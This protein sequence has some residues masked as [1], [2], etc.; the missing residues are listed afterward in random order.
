MA[1]RKAFW[2]WEWVMASNIYTERE[3]D[4]E[5]INDR[6]EKE[7]NRRRRTGM[8]SNCLSIQMYY[9]DWLCYYSTTQIIEA[10]E[11]RE[12]ENAKEIINS[13][14]ASPPERK[15]DELSAIIVVVKPK[16]DRQFNGNRRHDSEWQRKSVSIKESRKKRKKIRVRCHYC[17]INRLFNRTV[18]LLFICSS[19]SQSVKSYKERRKKKDAT[20]LLR[21]AFIFHFVEVCFFTHIIN[22]FD[23]K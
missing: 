12:W 1:Q 9:D 20:H 3:K 16:K 19:F 5:I 6:T 8:L 18:V 14:V 4:I 11:E 13:R 22:H 17:P 21:R 2:W 23:H 15:Y 10:K 7:K